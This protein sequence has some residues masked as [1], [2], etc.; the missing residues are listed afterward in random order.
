MKCPAHYCWSCSQTDPNVFCLRCCK[1]FHANHTQPDTRLRKDYSILCNNHPEE[2]LVSLPYHPSDIESRL[3]ENRLRVE[4]QLSPSQIKESC[5]QSC[6]REFLIPEAL[7]NPY[8]SLDH[9][10]Y[11]PV[12]IVEKA[13][14]AKPTYRKI[15][16]HKLTKGTQVDWIFENR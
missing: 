11:L 1:S 3:N 7:P 9:H 4:E 8:K 10:F 5:F 6:F 12:R 2:K 16:R 13:A 15:S 14:Q